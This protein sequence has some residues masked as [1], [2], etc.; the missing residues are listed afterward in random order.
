M[1]PIVYSK[2]DAEDW[3][4]MNRN[5]VLMCERGDGSQKAVSCYADAVAFFDAT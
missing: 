2:E 3:F 5:G 4:L 1:I